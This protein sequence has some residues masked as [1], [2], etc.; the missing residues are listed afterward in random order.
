MHRDPKPSRNDDAL[1][2]EDDNRLSDTNGAA[3]ESQVSSNAKLEDKIQIMASHI[4][5]MA[6]DI[7]LNECCDKVLAENDEQFVDGMVQDVFSED[8]GGLLGA[9]MNNFETMW[10]ERRIRIF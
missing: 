6:V 4:L 10:E 9:A 1:M 8:E 5:D 3:M 7:T 2:E